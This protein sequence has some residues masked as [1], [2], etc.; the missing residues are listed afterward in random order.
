[1]VGGWQTLLLDM[2]FVHSVARRRLAEQS[3]PAD[4]YLLCQEWKALRR[5]EIGVCVKP[6][7]RVDHSDNYRASLSVSEWVRVFPV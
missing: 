2:N 3:C 5:G 4:Q 1:M 6:C 7:L